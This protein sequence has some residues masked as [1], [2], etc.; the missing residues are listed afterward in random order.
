MKISG[1]NWG[2]CCNSVHYVDLFK[3][4]TEDRELFITKNN[5]K[6]EIFES[7][8]IGYFELYGNFCLSNKK[9]DK[10]AI[11]CSRYEKNLENISIKIEIINEKKK[12]VCKLIE[13]KLYIKFIEG[14]KI[15][16]KIH[17][18]KYQSERTAY[19]IKKILSKKKSSLPSYDTS[20]KDHLNVFDVFYCIF[21]QN[22]KIIFN[23]LPI[24]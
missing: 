4:F 7:K 18:F 11:S 9:G 19:E 3:S 14:K 12:I 1:K 23:K 10:L 15:K 13:N 16:N 17:K 24:T 21:N 8:R 2:L 22:N 5:L 20:I 6:N